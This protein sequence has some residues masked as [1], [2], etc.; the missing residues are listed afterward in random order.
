MNLGQLDFEVFAFMHGLF[1]I[2]VILIQPALGEFPISSY[3][4]QMNLRFPSGLCEFL[5]F[6]I[7]LQPLFF[8]CDASNN[9]LFLRLDFL[10]EFL[11]LVLRANVLFL[12]INVLEFLVPPAAVLVVPESPQGDEQQGPR[13]QEI[14]KAVRGMLVKFAFFKLR[15]GFLLIR[16][17]CHWTLQTQILNQGVTQI[18]LILKASR[19]VILITIPIMIRNKLIFKNIRRKPTFLMALRSMKKYTAVPRPK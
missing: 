3:F 10:G 13:H 16:F 5:I 7:G 11:I 9:F 12:E 15:L 8:R 14:K 17:V 4:I 1:V 18:Y 6:I 2:V 19:R